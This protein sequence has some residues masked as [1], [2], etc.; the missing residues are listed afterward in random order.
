MIV[1]TRPLATLRATNKWMTDQR[2]ETRTTEAGDAN[3]PISCSQS[4]G[5]AGSAAPDLARTT[6]TGE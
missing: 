2:A 5:N 3:K 6:N 1:E 4:C